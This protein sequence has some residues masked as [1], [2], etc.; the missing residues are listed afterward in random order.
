M[1]S[2]S[3]QECKG[4]TEWVDTWLKVLGSFNEKIL[5]ALEGRPTCAQAKI[6]RS[7]R[8]VSCPVVNQPGNPERC[9]FFGRGRKWQ[10]F[11]TISKIT[12][13][14]HFLLAMLCFQSE[15]CC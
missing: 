11:P 5:D 6:K 13:S 9:D 3:G 10:K 4:E 2:T 1:C 14:L 8:P 7:L 12:V 15:F